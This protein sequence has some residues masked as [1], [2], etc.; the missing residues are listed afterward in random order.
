MWFSS[1][2]ASANVCVARDGSLRCP[3]VFRSLLRSSCWGWGFSLWGE[4]CVSLDATHASL[5]VSSGSA[6]STGSL[7]C[8]CQ[9]ILGKL[10][11]VESQFGSF[12]LAKVEESLGRVDIF[13]AQLGARCTIFRDDFHCVADALHESLRALD[14]KLARE[15]VARRA[16]R[17]EIVD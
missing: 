12:L 1:A 16:I 7:E 6:A 14:S 2:Q 8:S 4:L 13:V 15:M 10:V 11:V 5:K 9:G 3:F 17:T